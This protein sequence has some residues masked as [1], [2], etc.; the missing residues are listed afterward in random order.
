MNLSAPNR[1][2]RD[3]KMETTI[4][5]KHWTYADY[6]GL[7]DEHRYEII[8]GERV[9]APAPSFKHQKIVTRLIH[10]LSN[11]VYENNAGEIIVAPLDLVLDDDIVL[12]PD[13]IFISQENKEIIKDAAVFGAPDLVIE[14]L[15]PASI[16]RDTQVKKSIYEK[17]GVKEYWLVFPD[18]KV[19]EIF[20]L[21]RGKYKLISSAEKAGKVKGTV[22]AVAVEIKDIF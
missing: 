4:L 10:F 3:E 8:E 20:A 16:Y 1:N 9:M 21:T 22:L 18:E 11:A 2:G 15:S 5:Q 19:I 14:I 7:D 6:S 12:Q 13:I 17:A